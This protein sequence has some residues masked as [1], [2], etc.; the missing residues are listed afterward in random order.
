MSNEPKN[1]DITGRRISPEEMANLLPFFSND[2][3][4]IVESVH[5]VEGRI[6]EAKNIDAASTWV[7][8]LVNV[9]LKSFDSITEKEE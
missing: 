1:L 4:H 7:Q 5:I 8:W 3:N 6:K 9:A 2:I